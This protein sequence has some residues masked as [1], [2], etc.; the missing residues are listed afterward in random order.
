MLTLLFKCTSTI[1]WFFRILLGHRMQA[2][3]NPVSASDSGS[4]SV[5]KGFSRQSSKDTGMSGEQHIN[6]A[7]QEFAVV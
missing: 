4:C 2:Y 1:V 7:W 6:S 3:T 5:Y